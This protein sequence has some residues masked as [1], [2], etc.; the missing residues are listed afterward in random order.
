MDPNHLLVLLCFTIPSSAWIVPQPTKNV[1]K[2]LAQ[3]LG[4]DNIC[5]STS[6]AADPFLFCLVGIQYKLDD[7]PFTFPNPTASPSKKACSFTIHQLDTWRWVKLLP[8]MEDSPQELD[9]LGYSPSCT[10]IHFDVTPDPQDWPKIE[11]RQSNQAY[12]AKEWCQRV[13]KIPMFS[14]PDNRPHSLPKGTFLICGTRAWAGIPPHLIGGPCIFGQLSLFIPN[15]T[16]ISHWKQIN[17]TFQLARLKRDTELSNLDKN[18]DSEIFHWSKPKGMDTIVF[19]P[20]VAIAHAFR[21]LAGLECW[22]VKQANV[23][24]TALA[25][26]LL[27]EE[28]TRQATLQNQAAIDFLLLLHDHSCEEFEGLCCMN[29]TSKGGDVRKAINKLQDMIKDI[30]KETGDWLSVLVCKISLYSICHLLEV[31]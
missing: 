29:L 4:Q 30:K 2:T 9:L 15:Q 28:V 11:V 27:D 14:T 16:K 18:C 6:S 10:C 31:G 22:V 24:S 23:T 17:G 12:T 20:W 8:L 3:A 1:W 13:I 21:E 26:L 25:G 19:L 7:F 5:L